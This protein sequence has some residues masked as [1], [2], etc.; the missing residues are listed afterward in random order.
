M[1]T[2]KAI[3][4]ARM[5]TFLAVALGGIVTIAIM[6]T[7]AAF[8]VDG[9]DVNSAAAMAQQLEPLLG[10]FA[11]LFFSLGLLAAGL[12]SA[13]T[14]PLAAAYAMGGA[15]GW[16]A[17]MR[18]TKYR[19]IWISVVVIGTAFAVFGKKPVQAII[20]AQAANGLI[21]PVIAIFL[22]W[23]VNKKKLLGEHVNGLWA[24][25]LGGVVVVIIASLGI[26]RLVTLIV[27]SVKDM[28]S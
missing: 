6:I 9:S 8:F 15:L 7:A 22:L 17:D 25:L 27:A 1:D 2:H 10:R 14:A 28:G 21:L 4:E 16:P 3:R 12:T 23:V 11:K 19:A 26:Y 24:N 18:S 20:F 5:D 13:I